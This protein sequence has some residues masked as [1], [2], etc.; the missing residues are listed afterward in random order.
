MLSKQEDQLI[1]CW[2]SSTLRGSDGTVNDAPCVVYN[3]TDLLQTLQMVPGDSSSCV[4][5]CHFAGFREGKVKF[6]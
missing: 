3:S 1:I 6:V 5:V 4:D 2:A